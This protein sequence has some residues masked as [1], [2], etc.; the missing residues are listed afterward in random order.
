M[1]SQNGV[2][3]KIHWNHIQCKSPD[4]DGIIIQKHETN[5]NC[6][7]WNSLQGKIP[8]QSQ[9]YCHHQYLSCWGGTHSLTLQIIQS[10]INIIVKVSIQ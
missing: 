10:T 3:F 2:N 9:N 1:T 4:D 7:V 6:I 8:I 5:H